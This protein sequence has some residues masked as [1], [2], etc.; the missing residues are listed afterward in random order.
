MD[1]DIIICFQMFLDLYIL[2]LQVI[3]KVFIIDIISYMSKFFM[4]VFVDFLMFGYYEM[5]CC[6]FVFLIEYFKS[7]NKYDFLFFDF[8]V[9][10]DWEN[11][12]LLFVQGVK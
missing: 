4:F 6:D 5:N 2:D 11:L 9:C 10:K 3:V 1:I 8:G 7:G 12:L